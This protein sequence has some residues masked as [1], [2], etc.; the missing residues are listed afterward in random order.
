MQFKS[1]IGG[2]AVQKYAVGRWDIKNKE[3]SVMLVSHIYIQLFDHKC[4]NGK[5]S[6]QPL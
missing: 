1:L 6:K 4:E 3:G 2:V 5:S